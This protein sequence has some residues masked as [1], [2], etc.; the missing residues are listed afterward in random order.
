MSTPKH[1]VPR[2]AAIQVAVSEELYLAL[3]ALRLQR[4]AKQRGAQ[5][6]RGL[7]LEGLGLLFKAEGREMPAAGRS[8]GAASGE[9][10]EGVR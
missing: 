8:K 5:T 4:R 10:K 7:M 9:R 6:L 2:L 3:E 1:V